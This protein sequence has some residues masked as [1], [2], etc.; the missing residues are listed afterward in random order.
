MA[1][2]GDVHMQDADQPMA[3]GTLPNGPAIKRERDEDDDD[4]PLGQ[5]LRQPAPKKAKV[6]AS[7]SKDDDDDDDDMPISSSRPKEKPKAAAKRTDNKGDK[8]KD[9]KPDKANGARRSPSPSPA[10]SV[11][12]NG[13]A[14]AAPKARATAKP[15]RVIV[16]TEADFEPLNCWWEKENL[17][18]SKGVKDTTKQWDYLE[19][20]GVIFTPQYEPHGVKIRYDG[21]P[22]ALP[23]DAEEVANFW[24]QQLDGDRV[25]K[26]KFRTNFWKA[27]KSKL[28]K[29]HPIKSIDKCDFR[30]IKQHLDADKERKKNRSKE[31][32]EEEK[33]Q[34]AAYDA[35]YQFALVDHIREK[36]GNFRVEPPGLFMGRGEHPKQ[37]QLKGRIFP[38]QVT[39]NLAKDAPVPRIPNDGPPGHAWGDVHHNNTSTWLAWYKDTING[40]VKYVFLGAASGFKGMSDF[41]KYEKARKLKDYIGAIRDDYARKM[42]SKDQE[43]REL[44]T[45]VY[46]IDFLALRVGGEKDTEEEADT[47]G[48]CSLRKEHITFEDGYK[49]TLDF[50]GKDSIRYHQTSKIEEIAYH[51]LKSFC[52][53]KKD[54]EDIFDIDPA[55]LNKYLKELMPDLSAKV[56]RTYNASVTLQQ[57]LDKIGEKGVDVSKPDELL[58]FYND[59]NREVAILCNHQRS[60]PK[61]HAASMEKAQKKLD[62]L[63]EDIQEVEDYLEYLRTGKKKKTPKVEKKEE[64]E[65]ERKPVVKDGM[66]E[67]AAKKKLDT[68]KSQRSKHELTMKMKDDNKAVALSTSKINYMD[69][70]ITVA[71]CKKYEMTIEKVFNKGLRTKFPWAMYSKSDFVF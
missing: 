8:R 30:P 62:E 17:G 71:F 11:K 7:P 67:D 69:P 25:G 39:L 6:S 50:L 20:H 28:P 23:P 46:L 26:E 38:E 59:C 56:F 41:L 57:Q 66:K 40:A 53:G 35:P 12:A 63:N 64:G 70:R 5:A 42:K 19:H 22:M 37:G 43:D 54:D 51:N 49:I 33:K 15:K 2:A 16:K 58:S 13:A 10:S 65:K 47:V 45:A 14:R 60:V 52:K 29:D 18:A 36:I 48:C 32:K 27:F 68:L 24:A 9:L 55:R 31:E 21:E 4:M 3:N 1:S 34:K 44:G 61:G